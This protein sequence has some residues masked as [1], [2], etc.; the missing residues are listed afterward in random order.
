MAARK[1]GPFY[2]DCAMA[3]L[4]NKGLSRFEAD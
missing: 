3:S 2:I 1:G 4:A